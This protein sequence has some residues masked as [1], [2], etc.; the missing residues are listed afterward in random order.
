MR[1]EDIADL[2]IFLA[3]AE[4]GSFTGAANRLGLSQS[5]LSHSIRRLEDRLG[6]R[7]LVRTT[8]SVAP[9]DAGERLLEILQPA[10]NGIEGRLAELTALRQTPAGTIRISTSEH[11]AQAILWPAVD[12]LIAKYPDIVVEICTDNGFID[13]VADR[14]DAGVR[15]GEQVQKDM[16]A[17]R[18]GPRM[19]MIPFAS[20]H[21]IETHGAPLTPHDLA[22]HRCINL[23][24]TNAGGIYAWEFEKQGRAMHVKVEG[25]LVFNRTPLV[26]QAAIAGHGIGFLLEDAVA[27][28]IQ[29]GALVPLLDDWCEPF[30]GY[31]LYYPSRRHSSPA[32]KLLVD[33]LRYRERDEP[34]A[35]DRES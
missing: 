25:P 18:I 15:L 1:R 17:V 19:R 14:F 28:W 30:D 21:Y 24:F 4:E 13:I 10:M 35:H 8:R 12:R 32:F 23:R 3:V 26:I 33:E 20:P 2:T 5:G 16:I 34:A 7:L 31:F 11:A 27:P 29:K 22:R 6:L 9:T